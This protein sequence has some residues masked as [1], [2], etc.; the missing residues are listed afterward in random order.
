MRILMFGMTQIAVKGLK[1]LIS[2]NKYPVGMVVS[3]IYNQDIEN[4]KIIC[5]EH[6]I[7]V[8]CFENINNKEFISVVKNELKPDLLLT[9]T[10]PQKIGQ[11]LL[12]IPK[13]GI[14]MHPA[15]LPSY[16]GSNPYFWTIANGET[17]TGVTFH[18]LTSEFDAGDIILQEEIPI[19]PKDTCGLVIYRQE[20]IAANMLEKLLTLIETNTITS[21]PQPAGD[22]PKAPKPNINET[23]IHW[24]WPTSKIINRIRALNPYNGALTQYK[25]QLIAIYEASETHYFGSGKEKNGETVGLTQEGPMIKCSNGAIIIRILVVGKKYLLSGSDFIEYEK[26]KIGDKFIAW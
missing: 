20:E 13:L 16:R 4:I 25:N 11:E 5:H 17:M 7:P 23:F 2:L 3:P 26:L 1:R 15:L 8:Y 14:N 18:Y 10:F 6:S 22:F 21:T 9:Y 24:D 19:S 12:A